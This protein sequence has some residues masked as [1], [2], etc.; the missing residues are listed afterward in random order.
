M[1]FLESQYNQQSP[2]YIP[3]QNGNSQTEYLIQKTKSHNYE[4]S[5]VYNFSIYFKFTT[6]ILESK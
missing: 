6:I 2:S 3:K 5:I 4:I 1:K